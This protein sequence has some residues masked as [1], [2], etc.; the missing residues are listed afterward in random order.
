MGSGRGWRSAKIALSDSGST[1]TAW[2]AMLL[3]AVNPDQLS[4]PAPLCPPPESQ[5]PLTPYYIKLIFSGLSFLAVLITA[6]W[7]NQG[8]SQSTW[9]CHE[10]R[11]LKYM[12]VF[13]WYLKRKTE[14]YYYFQCYAG[15][16]LYFLMLTRLFCLSSKYICSEIYK[17]FTNTSMHLLNTG[18]NKSIC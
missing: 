2:E 4:T 7:G 9:K 10:P 12:W 14:S 1:L 15:E 13:K 3:L 6:L 11:A 18:R 16:L 5:I 8:E 17:Y